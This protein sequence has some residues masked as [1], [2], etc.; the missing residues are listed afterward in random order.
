MRIDIIKV[1][2][3]H[4]MY[5]IFAQEYIKIYIKIHIKIASTCFGLTTSSWSILLI[6][7]KVIIIKTIG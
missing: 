3:H 6:L 7:A 2:L 5:R 4:R 1:L